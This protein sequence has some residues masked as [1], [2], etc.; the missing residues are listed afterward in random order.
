MTARSDEHVLVSSAPHAP[1]ARD[2]GSVAGRRGDVQTAQDRMRGLLRANALVTG[3]LRL[4]VVLRHLEAAARDLLGAR[5]AALGVRGR[6]GGL[7]QFV[8]AGPDG[9]LAARPAPAGFPPGHPPGNGFVGVPICIGAEILGHLYLTERARGGEFTAEDEHLAIALAAAAGSAIANARRFAESEQRRRWLA[10]SGELTAV[11]LSGGTVQPAMLIT[12]HAAVAAEADFAML[13]HSHEAGQATV[14]G[15]SGALAVSLMNGTATLADSPAG[16]A[17]LTGRPGLV[18]GDLRDAT[19]VALGADIGP[20]IVAPLAAGGKFRGALVLGRLATAAYF[21]GAELDMA[22][23]FAGHAAVAL[24]LAEAR[25]DQIML[26][27]VEDHDRIAAGLHDHVI[28]E[29]FTLGMKLQGHVSRDDL[30]TAEQINDYVGALDE[31]IRQIRTSIF[32]LRRP[33]FRR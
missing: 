22:A 19:G 20:L 25:A 32:G 28:Q 24:E 9:D 27:Q 23:S 8:C 29:L 1:R 17:I 26:A 7:E 3:D 15:V 2:P 12:Q 4:P 16:H 11:L 18:T 6:D 31:I 21:T 33:E 13:W 14:T 10:A 5:Y 30:V